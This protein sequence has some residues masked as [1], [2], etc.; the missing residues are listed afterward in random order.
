[1]KK[2]VE[3]ASKKDFTPRWA[4][5]QANL[6]RL[7][8]SKHKELK[9]TQ[10]KA[11]H[12]LGFANQSMAHQHIRGI[13]ALNVESVLKWAK[14]LWVH[15][16]EIDPEIQELL[17]AVAVSEASGAYLL[18]EPSRR[19]IDAYTEREIDMVLSE[20]D[21]YIALTGKPMSQD[22]KAEVI[23]TLLPIARDFQDPEK[24]KPHAE[25]ILKLVV[26]N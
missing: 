8:E 16:A 17:P 13:T 7:W 15:P 25:R 2:T 23:R 21:S 5:A 3:P 20:V 14:L 18:S 19:P 12:K 10:E 1:M 24:L 11:A 22:K 26:S 9:L 4:K 6:E